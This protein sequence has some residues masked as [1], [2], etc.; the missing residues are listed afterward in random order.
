MKEKKPLNP[1]EVKIIHP[2]YQPSRA[3]LK[4]DLRIPAPATF[5]QA[6]KALVSPV[7]IE[8]VKSPK[9]LA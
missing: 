2:S 6:V 3:E 8:Y 4:E 7:K 5:E 1:R 9:E